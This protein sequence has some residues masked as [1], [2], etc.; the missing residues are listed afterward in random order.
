MQFVQIC[1]KRGIMIVAIHCVIQMQI[2]IGNSKVLN[3]TG[4]AKKTCKI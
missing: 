3:K 2:H 1:T 4:S